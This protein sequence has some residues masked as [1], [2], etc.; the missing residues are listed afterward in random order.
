MNDWNNLSDVLCV[1][2]RELPIAFGFLDVTLALVTSSR[3]FVDD[4][5]HSLFFFKAVWY[6]QNSFEYCGTDQKSSHSVHR[7]HDRK[8]CTYDWFERNNEI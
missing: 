1:A 8:T 6:L 2:G 7:T 5:L 3:G 4:Y